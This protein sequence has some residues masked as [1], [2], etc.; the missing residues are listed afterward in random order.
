MQLR[1]TV[2]T[3]S[4]RDTYDGMAYPKQNYCFSFNRMVGSS[5]I[6]ILV[7]EQVVHRVDRLPNPTFHRT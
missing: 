3:S 5:D 7:V 2:S 4:N 6:E 1:A